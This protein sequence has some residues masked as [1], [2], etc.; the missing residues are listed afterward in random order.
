MS[1]VGALTKQSWCSGGWS[2]TKFQVGAWQQ[3]GIIY[4]SYL[5]YCK[6]YINK[7]IYSYCSFCVMNINVLIGKITIEKEILIHPPS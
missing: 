2:L 7:I 4:I 5:F 6:D 3:I 1:K